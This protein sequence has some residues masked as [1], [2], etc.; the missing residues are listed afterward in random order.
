[1]IVSEFNDAADTVTPPDVEGATV[2]RERHENAMPEDYD[3]KGQTTVATRRGYA[4]APSNK[5]IPVITEAGIKM[6][7]EQADEVVAESD[8]SDGKVFIVEDKED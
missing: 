1:M 5:A 8:R 7:R 4:F 6:T 3:T 2:I